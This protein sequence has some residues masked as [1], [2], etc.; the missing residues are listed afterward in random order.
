ML[1][2][3]QSHKETESESHFQHAYSYILFLIGF[4]SL[5]SLTPTTAREKTPDFLKRHIQKDENT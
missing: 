1:D 2:Y 3:A 5:F 4:G